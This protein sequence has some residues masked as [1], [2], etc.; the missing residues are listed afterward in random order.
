MRLHGN[1]NAMNKWSNYFS[2]FMANCNNIVSLFSGKQHAIN[3]PVTT[4][5][6]GTSGTFTINNS[7]EVLGVDPASLL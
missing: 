1:M 4:N 6:V 2:C 7:R 5:S 3:L